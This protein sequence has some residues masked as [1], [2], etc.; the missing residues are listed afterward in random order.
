LEELVKEKEKYKKIVNTS[1]EVPTLEHK[2]RLIFESE[3]ICEY[4]DLETG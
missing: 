1:G 3:I 2:E 4:I